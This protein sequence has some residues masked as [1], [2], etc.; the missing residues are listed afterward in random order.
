MASDEAVREGSRAAQH[1]AREQSDDVNVSGAT[2]CDVS[3]PP[4]AQ[5]TGCPVRAHH[6]RPFAEPVPEVLCL[7]T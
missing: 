6:R 3:P 7:W 4:Q 1:L 2:P 5:P